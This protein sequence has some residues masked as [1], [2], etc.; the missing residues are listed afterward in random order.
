MLRKGG[1]NCAQFAS[2]AGKLS[3]FFRTM[4]LLLPTGTG[5]TSALTPGRLST[6][7]TVLASGKIRRDLR[8]GTGKHHLLGIW[9]LERVDPLTEASL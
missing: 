3:V 4:N 7:D 6:I 2:F 5:V 1:R 9:L 8:P